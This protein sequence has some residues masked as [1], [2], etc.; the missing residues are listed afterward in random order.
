MTK[1]I[2]ISNKI[3][4]KNKINKIFKTLDIIAFKIYLHELFEV[5]LQKN[6]NT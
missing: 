2:F 1:I 3:D 4:W 6:L 5:T